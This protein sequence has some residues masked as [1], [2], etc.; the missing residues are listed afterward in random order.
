M[1]C[2]NNGGITGNPGAPGNDVV[3]DWTADATRNYTVVVEPFP[4]FDVVAWSTRDPN[5]A[6]SGGFC[7]A[8]MDNNGSGP[9]A[10]ETFTLSA[11]AGTRY[12]IVVDGFNPGDQGDFSLSIR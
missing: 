4:T 2:R 5:C 6:G 9:G 1:T 7:V 3:F 8:G 12:F 11:D 10:G